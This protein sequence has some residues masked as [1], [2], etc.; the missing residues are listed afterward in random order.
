MDH[1]DSIVFFERG[2]LM[3]CPRYDLLVALDRHERVAEPKRYEKL[4]HRRTRLDLPFLT[5]DDD[6]HGSGG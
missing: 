6:S 2:A 1:F 3:A 4:L 5:I